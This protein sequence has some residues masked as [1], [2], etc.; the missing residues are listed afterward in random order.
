MRHIEARPGD[1]LEA[2]AGTEDIATLKLVFG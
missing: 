2:A 1:A